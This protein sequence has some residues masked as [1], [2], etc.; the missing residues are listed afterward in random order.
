MFSIY[1]QEL[2]CGTT[3]IF[4]SAA[5][6]LPTQ[7][8]FLCHPTLRLVF[9]HNVL[10]TK[11]LKNKLHRFHLEVCVCVVGAERLSSK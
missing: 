2:I 7:L 6:C 10:I 11:C 4:V 5:R 3:S 8:L 1:E 9:R